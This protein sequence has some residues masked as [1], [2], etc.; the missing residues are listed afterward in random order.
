MTSQMG[1]EER[2]FSDSEKASWGRCVVMGPLHG[3][4]E[5]DRSGVSGERDNVLLG[6]VQLEILK[7]TNGNI[8]E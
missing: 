6:L 8:S 4:Q 5:E 3:G 7:N 2:V 1:E